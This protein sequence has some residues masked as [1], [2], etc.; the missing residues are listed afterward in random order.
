[1]LK[2]LKTYHEDND[3]VEFKFIHVFKRIEK[4]DKWALVRVSL[5]KGKYATFDPT[6]AL[7]AAG[8]GRP[9][10][11]EQEGQACTGRGTNDG[12]VAIGHRQVHH[13][14]GDEQRGEE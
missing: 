11:G 13:R 8:K 3:D 12:K 7:P 4:C 10:I 5:G 1:M 2:M 6:A 14:C 9:E